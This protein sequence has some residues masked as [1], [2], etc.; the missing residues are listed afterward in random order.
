MTEDEFETGV[1]NIPLHYERDTADG[2]AT[3]RRTSDG[4]PVYVEKPA[5]L[6]LEDRAAALELLRALYSPQRH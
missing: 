5:N 1:R 3:I 4:V 6:R 2:K